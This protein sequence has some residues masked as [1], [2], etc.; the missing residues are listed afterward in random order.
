MEDLIDIIKSEISLGKVLSAK[1]LKEL[2]RKPKII[3]Y[4]LLNLI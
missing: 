3:D 4:P 1:D 2:Q